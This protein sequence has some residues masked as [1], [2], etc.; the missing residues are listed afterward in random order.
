MPC[1]P[2]I[3]LPRLLSGDDPPP[4]EPPPLPIEGGDGIDGIDGGFGVPAPSVGVA[5]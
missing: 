5:L 2:P 1:I 4:P 3:P